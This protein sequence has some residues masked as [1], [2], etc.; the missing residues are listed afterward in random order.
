MKWRIEV[1]KT[2]ETSA[3]YSSRSIVFTVLAECVAETVR[4]KKKEPG[5]RILVLDST[6][7]DVTA[8]HVYEW[9]KKANIFVGLRRLA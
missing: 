1:G 4:F 9:V 5:W 3:A 2:Y 7:H 6:M 8:G